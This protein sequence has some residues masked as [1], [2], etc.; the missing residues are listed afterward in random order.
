M[1]KFIS[2]DEVNLSL[3]FTKLSFFGLMKVLSLLNAKEIA[4]G[5]GNMLMLGGVLSAMQLMFSLAARL[6][7]GVY[8]KINNFSTASKWNGEP[9]FFSSYA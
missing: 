2:T 8:V 4:Q 5:I 7:G 3:I 6:S 1:L 9:Q